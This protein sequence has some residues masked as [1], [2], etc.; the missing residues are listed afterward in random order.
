MKAFILFFIFLSNAKAATCE[1][2]S[3]KIVFDKKAIYSDEVFCVK[4]T[5][6]NMIFYV[7][8]SCENDG[9]DILKRKKSPIKIPNYQNN[10]GSPGFKLCEELGGVPQIF[11]F[12]KDKKQALWQSTE[13]CLF[14]KDFVEIS[15]LSREWKG[16]IEKGK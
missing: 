4:K 6:D 13:R 12:T 9:C 16:F 2:V 8:K 11:E 3:V 14:N 1:N 15:L 10:I 7:S 5:S